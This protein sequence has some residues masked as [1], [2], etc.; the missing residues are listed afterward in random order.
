[1]TNEDAIEHLVAWAQAVLPE[2]NPPEKRPEGKWPLPDV[3]ANI[4]RTRLRAPLNPRRQ[5]GLERVRECE[6]MVFVES[7]PADSAA[8]AVYGFTDRLMDELIADFTL[9]G[10]VVRAD[11]EGAEARFE[12]A[13]ATLDDDTEVR[14]AVVAF[15]VREPV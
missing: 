10:R 15:T 12:P 6:L 4:T 8:T 2:L 13:F 7:E 1:M 3:A 9:G 5:Q 14:Q 11:A